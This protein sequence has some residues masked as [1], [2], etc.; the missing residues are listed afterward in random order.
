MPGAAQLQ[1]VSD[2]IGIPDT[3]NERPRESEMRIATRCIGAAATLALALCAAP[4]F[5]AEQVT[6]FKSASCGCCTK[7]IDHLRSNGFEVRATNIEAMSTVRARLGVPARL[8]SCHTAVV[9]GYVIEGHVPA[10]DIRRLMTE[11]AKVAGLAAPGMSSG[12]PGM[13]GPL[14]Q[15]Y[16][17]MSFTKDGTTALFAK[18]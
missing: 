2:P 13:E 8:A 6:V 5:A 15:P 14:P 17:V 12:S 16:S 3:F 7:W 1:T 10:S 9:G 4:A 18:H 11:R